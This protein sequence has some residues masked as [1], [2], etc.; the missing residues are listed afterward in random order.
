MIGFAP[1]DLV[2]GTEGSRLMT[3]STNVSVLEDGEFEIV[4]L[5]VGK[6]EDSEVKIG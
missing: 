2:T 5:S 4:G 3:E 6:P 1:C